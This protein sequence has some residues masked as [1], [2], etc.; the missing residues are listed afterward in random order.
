VGRGRYIK[1]AERACSRKARFETAAS[2][3]AFSE[4]RFKAYLCPICH[5]WHLTSSGKPSTQEPPAKPEEPGPKFRDLDWSRLEGEKSPPKPRP[6]VIEPPTPKPPK[7]IAK[8][9]KAPD[10]EGRVLLVFD[11]R[12]VKSTRIKDKR[13]LGQLLAGTIVELDESDPPNILGKTLG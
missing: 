7:R 8:C 3:E 5:H 9:V 12:L 10:K 11:G 2:A 4:Y 13:L 6:V 1:A